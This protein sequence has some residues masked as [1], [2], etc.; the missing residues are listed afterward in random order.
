MGRWAFA[1]SVLA[2]V[3]GVAGNGAR[4]QDVPG[5]EICTAE[6]TMER[7]TGCLQSNINFLQDK[8]GKQALDYQKRLDAV[9]RQVQ[10][11]SATVVELTRSVESL[12]QAQADAGKVLEKNAVKPAD[13]AAPASDAPAAAS[14][15]K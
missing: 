14:T 2:M 15:G 9:T 10:A 11:L 3:A 5:I 12:R 1:A 6:K 4:A 8:L 7:R 13:K